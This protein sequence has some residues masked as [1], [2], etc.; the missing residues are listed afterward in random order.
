MTTL[1][2]FKLGKPNYREPKLK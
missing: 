1:Y 2:L